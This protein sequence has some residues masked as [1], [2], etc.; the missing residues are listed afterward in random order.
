MYDPSSRRNLRK[1]MVRS[2]KPLEYDA[3]L[4]FVTAEVE[5]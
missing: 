2:K 1:V 4:K 3:E 5:R